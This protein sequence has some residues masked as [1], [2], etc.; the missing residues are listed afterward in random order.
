[1]VFIRTIKDSPYLR[2]VFDL[3]PKRSYY[4]ESKPLSYI[5]SLFH[6]EGQGSLYHV[7]KEK[8]LLESLELNFDSSMANTLT[9]ITLT[10][11][12][13]KEGLCNYKDIT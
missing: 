1:M 12:L 6:Y 3:E 7:L 9:V 2:F 8:K 4:F 13:T 5:C 11:Y 10:V